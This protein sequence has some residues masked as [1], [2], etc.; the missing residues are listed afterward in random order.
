MLSTWCKKSMSLWL[1]ITWMLAAEGLTLKG[2][3]APTIAAC[4]FHSGSDDAA[5]NDW[6]ISL[7]YLVVP[8]AGCCLSFL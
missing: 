5:E 7:V 1:T 4:L 2:K 3:T 8:I 6:S